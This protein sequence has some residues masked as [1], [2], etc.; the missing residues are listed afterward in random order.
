MSGIIINSYTFLK[1]IDVDFVISPTA[2]NGTAVD[3]T[4]MDASMYGTGFSG[5][6]WSGVRAGDPTPTA[7]QHTTVEA[8]W[9]ESVPTAFKTPS[10][11]VI[12]NG[13]ILRWDMTTAVAFV[14][15]GTTGAYAGFKYATASGYITDNI[16]FAGL[17][18]FQ[19]TAGA[20][21]VTYE[22]LTTEDDNNNYGVVQFLRPTGGG[23]GSIRVERGQSAVTIRGKDFPPGS[24]SAVYFYCVRRNVTAGRIEAMVIDLSTRKV[25]GES[26][27]TVTLAGMV[28]F[29][30]R[31]YLI[32]GNS[33]GGVHE[34]GIMGVAKGVRAVM[35][36]ATDIT[37][38][39]VT[40]LSGS[41]T[42]VNQ[43]TVIWTS[44]LCKFM[45]EVSVN[46][47]AYSTLD[48]EL[49]VLT[50][51]N[52]NSKVHTGLTDG[53][54]YTYR[55]TALAGDSLQSTTVTS[56]GV[57]VDNNSFPTATDDFNGFTG[58]DNVPAVSALWDSRTQGSGVATILKPA[59]NGSVYAGG[60]GGQPTNVCAVYRT[61]TWNSDQMSEVEIV[62]NTPD[63]GTGNKCGAMVRCQ[64]G[65]NTWYDLVCITDGTDQI[66]VRSSNAGTFANIATPINQ[67]VA[68]GEKLRIKA[69][70]AGTATRIVCELYT[71][72]VWTS[73][74]NSVAV[75]LD[76]TVDIDNG[77]PGFIMQT[78]FGGSGSNT[79]RVDNW[80]GWN[81]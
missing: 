34:L 78:G 6:T 33:P 66:L 9:S 58:G 17:I 81:L 57:L 12:S 52:S 8:A 46:G 79:I 26:I 61:D 49:L 77:T 74:F 21:D 76:P 40:S 15:P 14:G 1:T 18:K 55:V 44:Y 72:G 38:D 47:G 23:L 56:S 69:T 53:S 60:N 3:S 4:V 75:P 31:D 67:T 11:A 70:G 42:A 28:D 45:V 63:T 62:N 59:S 5:Y 19:E 65:A 39:P 80:K 64:A 68:V 36:L 50:G 13:K 25:I 29:S 27:Y 16:T 43:I 10:G 24:S 71:G 35:P 30:I 48:S 7:T 73:L 32:N 41:Q 20:S 22:W 51:T 37:I 2:T 54:T